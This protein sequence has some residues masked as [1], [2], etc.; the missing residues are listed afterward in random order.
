MAVKTWDRDQ[1]LLVN[2]VIIDKCVQG[3]SQQAE[4]TSGFNGTSTHLGLFTSG[5]R[6]GVNESSE[7]LTVNVHSVRQKRAAA[8]LGAVQSQKT[9]LSKSTPNAG[10]AVVNA[11]V[12]TSFFQ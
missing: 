4:D 7:N 3:P 1:P 5:A 2:G 8:T 10:T 11:P 6:V 12:T 9:H